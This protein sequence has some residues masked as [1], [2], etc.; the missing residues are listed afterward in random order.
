MFFI[1]VD[2]KSITYLS[3]PLASRLLPTSGGTATAAGEPPTLTFLI[4]PPKF[5]RARP[6]R[7]ARVE[8]RVGDAGPQGRRTPCTVGAAAMVPCRRRRCHRPAGGCDR[9]GAAVARR[10]ARQRLVQRRRRGEHVGG[11]GGALLGRRRRC[12]HQRLLWW[13]GGRRARGRA[14][15]GGDRRLVLPPHATPAGGAP[16]AVPAAVGTAAGTSPARPRWRPPALRRRPP[17]PRPFRAWVLAAGRSRELHL[18][19]RC[20]GWKGGARRRGG[21]DVA[22]A[23]RATAGG[24]R[25]LR[26]SPPPRNCAGL[27]KNEIGNAENCI[28]G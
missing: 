18:W 23:T 28:H 8:P 3:G 22:A 21:R 2:W 4:S 11:G 15:G 6:L 26:R 1:F 12:R 10:A 20:G 14:V 19:H 7:D 9:S 17:V 25:C 13:S 24:C 27:R 16:P 5:Q